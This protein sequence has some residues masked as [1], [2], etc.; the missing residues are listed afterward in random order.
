[1]M[2]KF[3]KK[4]QILKIITL[5]ILL[6]TTLNL[7]A[8]NINTIRKDSISDKYNDFKYNYEDYSDY[9]KNENKVSKD[10]FEFNKDSNLDLNRNGILTFKIIG[11]ILIAAIILVI[12]YFFVKNK[13]ILFNNQT[14]KIYTD[15]Y[16]QENIHK[17]DLKELLNQAI[18]EQN[19]PLIIR[20]YFLIFLKNISVKNYISFDPNKTNTDYLYEIKNNNLRSDFE[21]ASYLYTYIW[22]GKFEITDDI[23][24]K[25]KQHFTSILTK[26]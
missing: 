18:L 11:Y 1:M 22:Y 2:T 16:L 4:S 20:Y 10:E 17:I 12:I 14:K 9:L 15:E 5:L 25:A 6:T 7:Y 21:Y 3:Y 19:K 23:F 24:N 13:G 8:Q 26:Y